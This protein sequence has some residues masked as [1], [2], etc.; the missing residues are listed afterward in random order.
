M[1][2]REAVVYPVLP[3]ATSLQSFCWAARMLCAVLERDPRSRVGRERGRVLAL[4]HRL[5]ALG[6]LLC[7][8][9]GVICP[10]PTLKVLFKWNFLLL[11]FFPLMGF[12]DLESVDG[13]I[14]GLVL[15]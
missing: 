2:T 10:D 8:A 15:R 4:Q 13:I 3:R 9:C 1:G 11:F 5:S 14:V 7:V 6:P 12:V